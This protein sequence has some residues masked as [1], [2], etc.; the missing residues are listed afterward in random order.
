MEKTLESVLLASHLR[1]R[2]AQFT[3]EHE[4]ADGSMKLNFKSPGKTHESQ[5]WIGRYPLGLVLKR[6]G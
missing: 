6:R 1:T 5:R 4:R 3:I 2:P